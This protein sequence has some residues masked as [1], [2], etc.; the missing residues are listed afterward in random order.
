MKIRNLISVLCATML[1]TAMTNAQN[2]SVGVVG[3]F[4]MANV[5]SDAKGL[6][7]KGITVFGFG[8]VFD[9]KLNKNLSLYIQPMY[10]QKGTKLDIPT[11]EEDDFDFFGNF[12]I[13]FK[14]NYIEIPI[15]FKYTLGSGN[16][17]PYLMAGP[18]VGILSSAKITMEIVDVFSFDT[19]MGDAAENMDYGIGFGGGVSIPAGRNSLFIEG[20]YTLGL[21]DVFNGTTE[22]MEEEDDLTLEDAN[23]KHRGFQIM[24]G[25]CI[26][27]GE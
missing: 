26:P 14:Y 25:F 11:G 5:S 9:Y 17:K 18:T 13:K 7:T 22:E 16:T 21:K 23:V 6:D 12:E 4:N 1:L 27:L 8:G 24:A 3:G 20:R 2:A 10:L 19:D 15:F